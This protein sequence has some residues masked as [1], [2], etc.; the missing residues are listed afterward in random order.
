M[1][2]QVSGPYVKDSFLEFSKKLS[3]ENFT[4]FNGWLKFLKKRHNFS[5]KILC[6]ISHDIDMEMEDSFKSQFSDLLE[7]YKKKGIL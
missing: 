2:A 7:N 3:V 4:V 1:N 6:G 5:Q